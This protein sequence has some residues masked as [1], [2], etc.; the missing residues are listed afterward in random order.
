MEYE[1]FKDLYVDHIEGRAANERSK[2]VGDSDEEDVKDN[3]S[4]KHSRKD[5]KSEAGDGELNNV[6]QTS[7][8]SGTR[9]QVNKSQLSQREEKKSNFTYKY[10]IPEQC[11]IN[12]LKQAKIEK[13][14]EKYLL[15]AHP[16]PMAEG[17]MLII[18]PKKEDQKERDLIVYRDYSLRKRLP[19]SEKAAKDDFFTR[20]AKGEKAVEEANSCKL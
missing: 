16:F 4:G 2:I 6:T 11:Y 7:A 12:I 14:K 20:T 9:S 8:K 13:L 3:R 1:E 19:T 17:E 10:D 15:I 5:A 18:Q